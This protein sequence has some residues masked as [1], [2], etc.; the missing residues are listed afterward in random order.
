MTEES[1]KTHPPELVEAVARAICIASKDYPDEFDATC[2]AFW[3][4]YIGQAISA[5]ISYEWKER[6]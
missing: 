5:I 1:A 3:K 2:D 6:Q 4:R